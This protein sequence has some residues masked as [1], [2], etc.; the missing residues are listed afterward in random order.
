MEDN[1]AYYDQ[2]ILDEIALK[3]SLDSQWDR[4]IKLQSA[5]RLYERG[6]SADEIAQLLGLTT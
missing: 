5:K 4:H 3:S 6:L 2:K 1:R